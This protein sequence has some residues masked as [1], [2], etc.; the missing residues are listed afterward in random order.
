MKNKFKPGD[1]VKSKLNKLGKPY[2]NGVKK[3]DIIDKYGFIWIDKI[4]YRDC[5]LSIV[6]DLKKGEEVITS[7]YDENCS[8]K[9]NKRIFIQYRPELEKPYECVLL[10]YNE[11][12]KKGEKYLTDFWSYAKPST[13]ILYK[14]Y[15]EFNESWI[16]EKVK[17]KDGNI[18]TIVGFDTS[19]FYDV[20]SMRCETP[21]ENFRRCEIVYFRYDHLF[22][23]FTW[24]DGSIFGDEIEE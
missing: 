19:G 20:P 5:K 23:E 18:F 13:K 24:L 10:R 17:D 22:E 2:F 8:N 3:I 6:C 9:N 11:Y 1:Y 7:N 12:F 15:K 16:G 14:P 4:G 21:N